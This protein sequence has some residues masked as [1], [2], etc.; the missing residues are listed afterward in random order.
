[1][2]LTHLSLEHFRNYPKLDIALP[3]TNIVLIEGMNAQGKTNLLEAIYLLALTRSFRRGYK[4][5]M[6]AWEQPYM[7]IKGTVETV[8]IDKDADTS[9]TH[10][11]DLEFF[12]STSPE[13]RKNFKIRERTATSRQFIGQIKV[14]LFHTDD[15][16]MLVGDPGERRKFLN[17]LL[18]QTDARYLEALSAYQ[19]ILKQRNSCLKAIKFGQA[20]TRELDVWN[21]KLIENGTTLI[22]ARQKCINLLNTALTPEY[23]KISL[24]SSTLTI[25]YISSIGTVEPSEPLDTTPSAEEIRSQF[26]LALKESYSDDLR[27]SIT[28]RGPH[29]D[30]FLIE[31]NGKNIIGTTSRGELRSVAVAL[32]LGEVLYMQQQTHDWPVLLLDDVFSELDQNRQ[33]YLLQMLENCQ[34]II[35]AIEGTHALS[36][37]P[38][39]AY[40]KIDNGILTK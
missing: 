36:G 2:R 32:K 28:T 19:Q 21:E 15:I 8:V 22:L 20:T 31:L 38:E 1:M 4:D 17:T 18:V 33:T 13:R 24:T 26:T 23:E 11:Q 10:T 5:N 29:R 27:A 37:K 14:V 39:V 12:A 6:I 9:I 16:N 35:T 3:D 34:T 30:D 25:Q 40:W 7:R